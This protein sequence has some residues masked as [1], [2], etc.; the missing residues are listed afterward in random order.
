MANPVPIGLVCRMASERDVYMQWLRAAN[1]APVPL[2]SL[3]SLARQLDHQPLEALVADAEVVSQVSLSVVLQ[4]LTANRPL[5]IIGQIAS[6]PPELR[7]FASWLDRPVSSNELVLGLALALAEGRPARRSV[8]RNVLHLPATVDGLRSEVLDVS[9]EGVRL[10]VQHSSS[11]TLP[12]YFTLRVDMYGVATV[13]HRAWTMQPSART[14]LCGGTIH[15]LL[16]RSKEWTHLV[17]V[18]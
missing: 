4:V 18:A 1:Y 10:K 15:R 6:C 3:T 17:S 13:V 16:P 7:H 11:S 12:P 5:V 8:R 2:P 9:N 14:V